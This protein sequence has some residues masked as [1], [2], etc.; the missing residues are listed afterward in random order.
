MQ[1]KQK[2]LV[3]NSFP[4]SLIR[5]EVKM[6]VCKVEAFKR[7]CQGAQMYSFWGHENTLAAAESVLGMNLKPKMSRPAV[8]LSEEEL[9]MFEGEVFREC[10]VLSPNYKADFRPKIGEEVLEEQIAS[11]QLLRLS[12]LDTNEEGVIASGNVCT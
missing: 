5:R 9:P 8:V 3:G 11:W 12:W 1:G 2:V 4:L 7:Q 10:Y 6:E